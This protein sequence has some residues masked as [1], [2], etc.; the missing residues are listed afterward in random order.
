VVTET[1]GA[2]LV[3]CETVGGPPQTASPY[4]A[5]QYHAVP[6]TYILIGWC[7]AGGMS[8]KWLRDGFFEGKNYDTLTELAAPIPPG[9]QG[10]LFYPY[11]SGAGTLDVDPDVRGVFYGLE[12]HHG[13]A[14]FIRAI[15]EGLAYTLR[16]IVEQMEALGRSCREIRSLGGGANSDLWNQIKAAVTGRAIITMSCPEAASLG[17]AILQACATQ[18]YPDIETAAKRMVQVSST[19]VPDSNQKELYEAAYQRFR[20]IGGRYFSRS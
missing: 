8:L 6:D 13:G 5:V 1:T 15:M 11:M 2:A 4:L 16:Q 12:L 10:L 14:H 9:S 19:V 17:T 20:S 18:T 7:N 3:V